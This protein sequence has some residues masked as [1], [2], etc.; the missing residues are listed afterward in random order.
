MDTAGQ[1]F[2]YSVASH[3][4]HSLILLNYRSQLFTAAEMIRVLFCH[5]D[6]STVHVVCGGREVVSTLCT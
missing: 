3:I 4:I 5:Y 1:V 2:I 6:N